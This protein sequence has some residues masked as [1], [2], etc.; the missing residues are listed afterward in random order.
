MDGLSQWTGQ[1]CSPEKLLSDGLKRL[2]RMFQRKHHLK[3]F[4][5]HFSSSGFLVAS[6]LLAA[7]LHPPLRANAPAECKCEAGS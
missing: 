7:V 2:F 1:I 4:R 3:T 6:S 5:K